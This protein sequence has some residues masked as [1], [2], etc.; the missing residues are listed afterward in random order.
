MNLLSEILV[1]LPVKDVLRNKCVCKAWKSLICE[2][3]FCYKHTLGLCRKYKHN[4]NPYPSGIFR[5]GYPSTLLQ[6]YPPPPTLLQRTDITLFTH[7]SSSFT[8]C[9]HDCEI[10]HC[11]IQQSCNGLLLWIGKGFQQLTN[12]F[13][14]ADGD[15]NGN[16]LTT[17]TKMKMS[18]YLSATG[19]W[20]KLDPSFPNNINNY[21]CNGVYCNGAIHWYA[22]GENS[23]H[24]D[25]DSLG[26]KTLP[27]SHIPSHELEV[28]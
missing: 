27:T 26:F 18:V 17:T 4:P 19:S 15:G 13:K 16:Q 21:S 28:V 12:F 10:R 22:L 24:F 11:E 23:L 2:P 14:E 1:H 25:I 3:Q 7:N 9:I 20:S 8:C 6:R 5:Q